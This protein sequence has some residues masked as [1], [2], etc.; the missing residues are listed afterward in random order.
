M[1]LLQPAAP[2]VGADDL[3]GPAHVRGVGVVAGQLEG[4]IR[5]DRDAEFDRAAGVVAPAAVG[6]LLSQ[7]VVGGLASSLLVLAAEEGHQQDVFGFENGVA[8]QLAAPVAVGALQFEEAAARAV[9]RRGVPAKREWACGER[10]APWACRAC[11]GR[12]CTAFTELL[13]PCGRRSRA[14]SCPK[15]L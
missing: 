10:R 1:K 5:L 4:E 9:E 15:R 13:S 7:D 11:A 12:V 2:P 14:A 3:A 8:L 6:L